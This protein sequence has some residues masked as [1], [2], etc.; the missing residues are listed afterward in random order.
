MW[1]P[2]KG[3]TI[4]EI[5]QGRLLCQFYHALDL[6]H[7]L[8]GGPWAF[9][10]HPLLVHRLKLGENPLSVP[11]NHIPF[12]ARVNDVPAGFFIECVGRMLGNFIER[13]LE[14]DGSNKDSVWLNYMRIRVEVNTDFPLERWKFLKLASG[15]SEKVTFLHERLNLFATFVGN[16]ITPRA[17]MVLPSVQG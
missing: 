15:A 11:L 13:F 12:W 1:R 16:W 14:Y 5:G 6:K 10:N 9:G 3:V 8:E 2:K 7:I 4:K 17:I